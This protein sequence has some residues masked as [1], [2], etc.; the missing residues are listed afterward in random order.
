M[1]FEALS[2]SQRDFIPGEILGFI[3]K[4]ETG[5]ESVLCHI[6]ILENMGIIL[7]GMRLKVIRI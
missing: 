2:Y 3:G 6:P 7:G 5:W 4:R 1:D